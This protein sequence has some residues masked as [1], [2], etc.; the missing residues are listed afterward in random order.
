VFHVKQVVWPNRYRSK[1]RAFGWYTSPSG[2]AVWSSIRLA[3]NGN[4]ALRH[5]K[6]LTKELKAGG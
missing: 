3:N 4:P 1:Q 6:L 2:K 5:D